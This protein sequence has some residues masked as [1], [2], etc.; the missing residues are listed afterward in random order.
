ML[1]VSVLMVSR[2]L[3]Y[4]ELQKCQ[5][6]ITQLNVS[7]SKHLLWFIHCRVS[8]SPFNV[9]AVIHSRLINQLDHRELTTCGMDYYLVPIQKF[10]IFWLTNK[11]SEHD[12]E[13][14]GSLW[15]QHPLSQ[16]WMYFTPTNTDELMHQFIRRPLTMKRPLWPQSKPPPTL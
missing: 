8:K 5:I 12:E 1:F 7:V 15:H 10:H 13:P 9:T 16:Q 4:L 11:C 3:F 2:L 6:K 14:G